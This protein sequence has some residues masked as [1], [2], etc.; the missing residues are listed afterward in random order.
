MSFTGILDTLARISKTTFDAACPKLSDSEEKA[1]SSESSSSSE[2]VSYISE[3]QYFG[4]EDEEVGDFYLQHYI[5]SGSFGVVWQA[6]RKGNEEEIVAVKISRKDE[7]S[8]REVRMLKAVGSEHPN[9]VQLVDSFPFDDGR[10]LV[11]VMNLME[12][13][14]FY[15]RRTFESRTLPTDEAKDVTRQLLR[16]LVHLEKCG[17]VHTD[18]KPENILVQTHDDGYPVIQLADFGAASNVNAND[19]CKYGKTAAYRSPEIL[20]RSFQCIR[21]PADLWSTVCVIFEL[22]AGTVLFDPHSSNTYSA[23][24]TGSADTSKELNKQQLSLMVELLGKFPRRF[25]LQN[26]DY[27]NRKGDLRGVGEIKQIDLRAILVVECEVDETLSNDLYQFLMP[28]LKYTPRLRSKAKTL[29]QHEF[30]S[31]NVDHESKEDGPSGDEGG[32]QRAEGED[33]PMP[34]GE[35]EAEGGGKSAENAGGEIEGGE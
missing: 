25:A 32:E 30:L 23:K 14:L 33:H 35:N 29:L 18:I 34:K 15:Y 6:H 17:I 26:R 2:S 28:C 21:P 9:I 1:S 16:A 31:K 22:F 4:E 12:T 8:D 27:F 13:N 24:S 20:C 7:L 3:D 11:M 5:G 10:R 19:L